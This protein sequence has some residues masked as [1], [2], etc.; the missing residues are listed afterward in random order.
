MDSR[1]PG[2]LAMYQRE[3]Q[4]AVIRVSIE[5]PRT[6]RVRVPGKVRVSWHQMSHS[7]SGCWMARLPRRSGY[8]FTWSRCPVG[9]TCVIGISPVLG[10]SGFSVSACPLQDKSQPGFLNGPEGQDAHECLDPFRSGN[11]F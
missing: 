8:V 2:G 1:G 9:Q 7:A 5:K 6:E 4:V 10:L 3:R 11:S